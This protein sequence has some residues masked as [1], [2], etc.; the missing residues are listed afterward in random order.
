M[1]FDESKIN[2]IKDTP[3]K[4]ETSMAANKAQISNQEREAD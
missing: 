2:E 4:E 3:E 1:I